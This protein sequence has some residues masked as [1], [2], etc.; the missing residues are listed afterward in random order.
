[1]RLHE[2]ISK[3]LFSSYGIKIPSGHKCHNVDELHSCINDII[4]GNL[5]L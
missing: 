1:M 2:H 4:F 3:E 5:S